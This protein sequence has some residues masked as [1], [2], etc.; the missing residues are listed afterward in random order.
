MSNKDDS[1]K[2][3]GLGAL[4]MAALATACYMSEK[5]DENKYKSKTPTEQT[6]PI[7]NNPQKPA[8]KPK[9]IT[10][11][12]SIDNAIEETMPENTNNE[13]IPIDNIPADNIPINQC[14]PRNVNVRVNIQAGYGQRFAYPGQIRS[15]EVRNDGSYR[16]ST[17]P[18]DMQRSFDNQYRSRPS[19]TRGTP[20]YRRS[21]N[22]RHY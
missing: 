17:M 10:P 16:H 12:T 22:G 3:F 20:F 13:D 19:T 9:I 8:A 11:D 21:G 18:S 7:T 1:L 14:P 6:R 5:A 15:I 4:T 2:W